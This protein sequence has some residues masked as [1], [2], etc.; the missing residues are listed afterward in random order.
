MEGTYSERSFMAQLAGDLWW[1]L[2]FRGV[3]T[4]I[5]GFYALVSPVFTFFV[6]VQ[7]LAIYFLVN[8]VMDIVGSFTQ[9]DEAHSP[10][11]MFIKGAL[12][13]FAAIVI[14]ARPLMGAMVTGTFFAVVLGL[15][16][17]W[18]GCTE[19]Y[20]CIKLRKEINHAWAHVLSGIIWAVFGGLLLVTPYSGIAGLT[21]ALGVFALFGGLSLI[22]S[23]FILRRES[24]VEARAE[25]KVAEKQPEHGQ[26]H[27]QKPAEEQHLEEVEK[28]S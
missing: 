6:F 26:A 20:Q 14:F 11:W 3:I 5:L 25:I 17:L 9:K 7:V 16:A 2:L 8:G 27:E 12:G 22:V 24:K 1:L 13:V 15:Y 18:Y 21:M 19:V 23:A 28:S 4:A 10:I